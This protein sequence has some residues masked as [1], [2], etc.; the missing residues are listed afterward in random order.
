MKYFNS[1][2]VKLIQTFFRRAAGGNSAGGP[3]LW[4]R[5]TGQ[6]SAGKK[7]KRK[8]QGI[9]G[10]KPFKT[11]RGLHARFQSC[12]NALCGENTAS[13]KDKPQVPLSAVKFFVVFFDHPCR[14]ELPARHLEDRKS[15]RLNSSH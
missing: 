13:E 5:K 9:F 11:A 14:G 2:N 7:E 6:R 10:Q 4:Q 1:E 12:R 8:K 15:T 3:S